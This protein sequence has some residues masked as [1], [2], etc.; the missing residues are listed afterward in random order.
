M[1][2]GLQ[3]LMG[4]VIAD[5]FILAMVAFAVGFAIRAVRFCVKEVRR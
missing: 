3:R 5:L 4:I 2:G 1:G